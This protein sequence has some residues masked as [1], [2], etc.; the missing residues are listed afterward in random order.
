MARRF[1]RGRK[2]RTVKTNDPLLDV[3]L[4]VEGRTLP[5]LYKL[6]REQ[7]QELRLLAYLA[8]RHWRAKQRRKA[9]ESLEADLKHRIL[10]IVREDGLI[11]L[12]SR[13]GRDAIRVLISDSASAKVVDPEGFLRYLGSYAAEIVTSVSVSLQIVVDPEDYAKLIAL[14]RENFGE[15]AAQSMTLGFDKGKLDK[16]IASGDLEEPDESLVRLDWQEPRLNTDPAN[17]PKRRAKAAEK[18]A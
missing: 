13:R 11:G 8:W 15:E 4:E 16:R 14:V 17:K 1:A 9:A 10:A 12:V 3:I 7:R 18:P 5:K 6:T 2:N